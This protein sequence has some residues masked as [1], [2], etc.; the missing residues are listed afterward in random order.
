MQKKAIER[1]EKKANSK[2]AIKTWVAQELEVLMATIEADYS[3][4]KL[5]Q[6]RATLSYQLEQLKQ[7]GN[8]NEEEIATISE[9]IKLRNTQ[10]AD[11]QQ[12]ILESD[13]G[14]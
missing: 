4:E 2:D 13:Q 6:D 14:K 5:M 11:F 9:F 7:S 10:I 8:P 1:Q 12:K 3:L